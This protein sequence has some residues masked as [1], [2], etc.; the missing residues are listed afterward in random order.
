[1]ALVEYIIFIWIWK[2]NDRIFQDKTF[3]VQHNLSERYQVIYIFYNITSIYFFKNSK[4]C[5]GV[6]QT[7]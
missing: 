7:V 2:F 1:M 4:K 6:Y 5:S 3:A